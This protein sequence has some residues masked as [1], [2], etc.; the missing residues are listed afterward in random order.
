MNGSC[1]NLSSFLPSFVWP[2]AST[3]IFQFLV[4]VQSSS[5]FISTVLI[6]FFL[7]Y[8]SVLYRPWSP[9]AHNYNSYTIILNY[10]YMRS[11]VFC[12]LSSFMLSPSSSCYL[13]SS[14][15]LSHLFVGLP[16]L[17]CLIGLLLI[18]IFG[19]PVLL[20]LSLCP[21]HLIICVV[22]N[23]FMLGSLYSF[24]SISLFVLLT[25]FPRIFPNWPRC[26]PPLF[27]VHIS[28]E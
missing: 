23:A 13:M 4:S 19:T 26:L 12:I 14:S 15:I 18:I 5:F 20:I 24:C 22:I 3:H 25:A 10:P 21:N 27:C 28:Q 6:I 1:Q 9:R 16:F 17:L 7:L 11:L 2:I 8:I